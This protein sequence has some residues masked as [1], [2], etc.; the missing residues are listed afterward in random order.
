MMVQDL[1]HSRVVTASA[2]HARAVLVSTTHLPMAKAGTEAVR[3]YPLMAGVAL[4]SYGVHATA[5]LVDA[6]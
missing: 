6:R 1:S 2:G 5:R 4:T 3:A